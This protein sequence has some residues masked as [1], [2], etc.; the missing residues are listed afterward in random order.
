MFLPVF[1]LADID[2]VFPFT[3][4]KVSAVRQPCV[5]AAGSVFLLFQRAASST[6]ALVRAA[7]FAGRAFSVPFTYSSKGEWLDG[8]SLSACQMDLRSVTVMLWGP[9][10]EI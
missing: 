10:L 6:L 8:F 9:S 2:M 7:G 3:R 1:T 5:P 4:G